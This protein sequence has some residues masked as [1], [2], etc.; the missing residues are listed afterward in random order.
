M[1]SSKTIIKLETIANCR[2]LTTQS[3]HLHLI[4]TLSLKHS[5]FIKDTLTMAGVEIGKSGWLEQGYFKD[6]R[7]EYYGR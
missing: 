4:H 3:Y 7:L 1:W 2:L 6:D 5:P